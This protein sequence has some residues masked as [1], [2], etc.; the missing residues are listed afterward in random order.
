MMMRFGNP[1]GTGRIL[2]EEMKMKIRQKI[3]LSFTL[4]LILAILLVGSAALFVQERTVSAEFDDRTSTVTELIGHILLSDNT[5]GRSGEFLRELFGNDKSLEYA[6]VR[7]P[8]GRISRVSGSLLHRNDGSRFVAEKTRTVGSAV[9]TV[10]FSRHD[11]NRRIILLR[12]Q[13]VAITLLAVFLVLA[14]AALVSRLLMRPI[15]ALLADFP[16]PWKST[17][18][19]SRDEIEEISS[20]YRD[21]AERLRE[22]FE[23]IDSQNQEIRRYNEHLEELVADRVREV[24][25]INSVLFKSNEVMLEELEMARR[26]QQGIIPTGDHFPKREEFSIGIE[27]RSMERIGGDLVDVIRIGKNGYGFLVADVSGHGIP[28]A[29]IATMAKVAFSDS[30]GWNRNPADVF[31]SVNDEL[32]G[33]I[34]DLGYYLTSFY[35]ILNLE[36]GVLEYAS[37][38]HHPAF[39]LKA[40][41]EHIEKLTAAGSILGV[42][43]KPRF[44][45]GRIELLPGDRFLLYTD[46]IVEARSPDGELYGH[47]RLILGMEEG[48]G[49]EPQAFVE[50]IIRD[51]DAYTHDAPPD[52]DRALMAVEFIRA[53][54]GASPH[55]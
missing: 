23:R 3:V 21:I 31:Q 15:E 5:N 1:D 33:F 41:S 13:Y 54:K 35:A 37:A 38:G 44:V 53:A 43:E 52:D 17:G 11:F 18:N 40:G 25:R 50:K 49:L 28:A 6:F 46:G 4:T 30:S 32:F 22:S 34:G 47:D 9:V 20:S 16:V 10:G 39:L 42:F 36:T 12:M 8:D 24:N 55:A 48:R 19:G 14:V 29:L 45:C 7:E 26:V 2:R 27:Y 51:V